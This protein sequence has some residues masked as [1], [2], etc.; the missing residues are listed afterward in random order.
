M[1]KQEIKDRAREIAEYAVS[2]T[3]RGGWAEIQIRIQALVTEAVAAERERCA[4]LADQCAS[5]ALTGEGAE[6]GRGV[7][8]ASNLLAA[9]IRNGVPA[10]PSENQP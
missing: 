2:G 7:T 4:K 10:A 9:A 1:T 3:S 6:I 5:S 8:I